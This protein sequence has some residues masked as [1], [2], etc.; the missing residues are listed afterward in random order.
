V[1]FCS[2]TVDPDA[3]HAT[4]HLGIPAQIQHSDHDSHSGLDNVVDA[5]IGLANDCPAEVLVPLLKELRVPFDPRDGF[6]EL[7]LKILG[8]IGFQES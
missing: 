2:A 5:K 1:F 7:G 8:S 4:N 3:Q 6:P